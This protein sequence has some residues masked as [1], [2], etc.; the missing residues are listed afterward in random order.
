LTV[1]GSH[2]RRRRAGDPGVAGEGVDGLSDGVEVV[3]SVVM[4][5]GV[6]ADDA[7]VLGDVAARRR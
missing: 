2:P 5:G 6:E 1:T 7:N 4:G 3:G